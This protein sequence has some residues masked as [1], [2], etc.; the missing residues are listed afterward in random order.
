MQKI[1]LKINQLGRIRSS[2]I[3]VSPLMVF[4][5]ESGL[6]MSYLAIL[7]HYFFEILINTHLINH[8]FLDNNID[9]LKLSKSY[10]DAGTALTIQKKDLEKWLAKDAIKYLGYMLGNEKLEGDIEVILPKNI[11]DELVFSYKEEMTG[12]VNAED[13][14]IILTLHSLSYRIKDKTIFEEQPYSF[15]LRFVLIAFLFGGDYQKIQTT[16]VL[17][18]SRGTALT[19]NIQPRTGLFSEFV[20]DMQELNR[21]RPKSEESSDTLL[22]LLSKIIEGEVVKDESSYIYKTNET[23]MPISAAAASI[24]EIAPLQIFAQKI[25]VSHTSILIEEPEAHL[26]P[27]KQ[28]MMADVICALSKAGA[29]VQITTHSDY[30]LRRFNELIQFGRLY[31]KLGDNE[32]IKKMSNRTGIIPDMTPDETAIKAYCLLI[33][34]EDGSSFVEE[35][36]L[37]DGIPFKTFID[38]VNQNLENYYTLREDYDNGGN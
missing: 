7:C 11:P 19:E 28:R 32:K 24:K 29:A 33:R 1:I 12:L 18:P 15:L 34:Q 27:L 30:F 31:K 16:F 3:E 6:G 5:G 2:K 36:N 21:A 23:Q 22:Q 4:S 25:D 9:Y 20:S 37:E 8:Y 38:A 17:P 14:D 35:Q 10:K 26:H 13:V